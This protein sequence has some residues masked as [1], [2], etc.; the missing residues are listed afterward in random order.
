[1][2]MCQCT[3]VQNHAYTN[4]NRCTYVHDVCQSSKSTYVHDIC[5]L[6]NPAK[7]YIWRDREIEWSY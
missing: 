3:H 5:Q 2:G 4:K 1:M 6:S 7:I